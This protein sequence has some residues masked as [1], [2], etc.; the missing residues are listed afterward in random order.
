MAAKFG[1]RLKDVLKARNISQKEF[2]KMSGIGQSAICQYLAGKNTPSDERIEEITKV[3][4]L[5]EDYFKGT[6]SRSRK[7]Y[8]QG[9]IKRLSLNETAHLMGISNIALANGIKAGVFPWA[10]A[11]QGKG[12]KQVYFINAAK[13]SETEGISL[14]GLA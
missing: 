9:A 6:T 1:E 11:M 2:S 5:P 8:G 10:Y 7:E 14:E 12:N 4:E 3:L 13:F